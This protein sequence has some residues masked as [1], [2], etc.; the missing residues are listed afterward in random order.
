MP[1][2]VEAAG[3]HSVFGRRGARSVRASVEDLV[4]TR[5]DVVVLAFC[6]YDTATTEGIEAMMRGRPDWEPVYDLGVPVVCVD[7]SAHFSRPGPR[8]VDGVEDLA[9]RLSRLA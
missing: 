9:S 2:L 4:T 5:P 6:G 1:D 8:V 3:G 7:G